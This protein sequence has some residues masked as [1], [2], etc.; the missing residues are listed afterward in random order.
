[1]LDGLLARGALGEDPG[2]SDEASRRVIGG[3][4]AAEETTTKGGLAA[5]GLGGAE[6][7]LILLTDFWEFP[8]GLNELFIVWNMVER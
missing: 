1:V 5:R 4:H 7:G 6:G 3:G 2:W 8:G